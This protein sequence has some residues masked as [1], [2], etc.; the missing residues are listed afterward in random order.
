MTVIAAILNFFVPGIGT[1]LVEK[2][3]LGTIQLSVYIAAV[4]LVVLASKPSI[5]VPL[6]IAA[7]FWGMVSIGPRFSRRD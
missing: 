4:L 6:M 7:W 5:G 1:L 2:V 3:L